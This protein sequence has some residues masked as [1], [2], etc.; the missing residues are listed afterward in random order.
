MFNVNTT[1]QPM[2]T[3]HSSNSPNK[4]EKEGITPITVVE[5][6]IS[7][8]IQKHSQSNQ[9]LNSP[10]VVNVTQS[11]TSSCKVDQ[12]AANSR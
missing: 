8:P 6:H 10:N 1:P 5:S 4:I 7:T 12:T 11:S 9:E 2:K 3:P